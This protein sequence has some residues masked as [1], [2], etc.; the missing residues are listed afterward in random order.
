MTARRGA[1]AIALAVAL[2]H[3]LPQLWEG[4]HGGPW[5]RLTYWD[6]SWYFA[7]VLRAMQGYL[8]PGDPFVL[9]HARDPSPVPTLMECVVGTA[10]R[11]L[12]LGND[13][14][15]AGMRAVF[16]A[17]SAAL[18]W[19]G[20]RFLGMGPWLAALA[21]VMAATDVSLT[22]FRP[23]WLSGEPASVLPWNRLVSPMCN[24]SLFFGAWVAGA[25]AFFSGDRRW[26]LGAGALVGL[27]F[28]TSY[29][30]WVHLALGLGV[31]AVVARVPGRW[32]TLGLGALAA[33]V[34]AAPYLLGVARA[35]ADPALRHWPWRAG[36][37]LEADMRWV[38]GHKTMWLA[39][40]AA[41]PLAWA[42]DRRARYLAAFALTGMA[43][44]LSPLVTRTELQT[45]HWL[46]YTTAGLL[47]ATVAWNAARALGWALG[48]AGRPRLRRYGVEVCA[49]LLLATLAHGAVAGFRQHAREAEGELF[50]LQGVGRADRG[51]EGAWAWLRANAAPGS[52]VLAP[53]EVMPLVPLRTGL[54]VWTDNHVVNGTVGLPEVFER[55]VVMWKLRGLSSAGV[56]FALA[57]PHFA[58]NPLHAGLPGPTF[59]AVE[60]AGYPALDAA[61][62]ERAVADALREYEALSPARAARL[63]ARHRLDYVVIPAGESFDLYGKL[64][65]LVPVHGDAGARVASV[66]GWR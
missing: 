36:L 50:S 22:R 58:I 29:F 65:D 14:V 32:R 37:L 62:K 24:L 19:A 59:R 31:F 4:F 18:L 7:R 20:L 5:S 49:A 43:L 42:R 10:A 51:F 54:W 3:V 1:F 21:A 6:E 2:V 16:P 60:A 52:V 47:G 63:G 53:D 12:Q 26:A 41:A 40:A 38:L 25:R 27:T 35:A 48:R 28:Y 39:L 8:P 66:R 45:H 34:V 30:Y 56:R 23:F 44:Y 15:V 17:L 46:G 13:A 64:I 9:E 33:L 61:W 57:G 55:N 11:V